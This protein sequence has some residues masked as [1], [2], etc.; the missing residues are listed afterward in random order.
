M[1]GVGHWIYAIFLVDL[2]A[3]E[4]NLPND[5]HGNDLPRY[6]HEGPLFVSLT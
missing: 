5:T 6:A 3:R 4:P 2:L 1:P